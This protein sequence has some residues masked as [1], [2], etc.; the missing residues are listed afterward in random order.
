MLDAKE[1]K[2]EKQKYN[3]SHHF[4]EDY[5]YMAATHN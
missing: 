5:Q 4:S 2:S 1:T 3:T